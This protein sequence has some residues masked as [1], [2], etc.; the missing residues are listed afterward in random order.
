M[1]S[2][3][4]ILE[5]LSAIAH[6]ARVLAIVW[7]V[8]IAAVVLQ[9][10]R[11]WRPSRRLAMALLL[12]PLVTAAALGFA[13]GLPFNGV[14]LGLG[15]VALAI[16]AAG[17]PARHVVAAPPPAVV[18]GGALVGFGCWY[19]HFVDGPAL[20]YAAPVGLIPCPTLA[21]LL[22]ATLAAGGFHSSRWSTAVAALGLFY[23]VVGV[24]WLG[25]WVDAVLIGGAALTFVQAR[26][27][28]HRQA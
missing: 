5:Q 27:L 8:V 26:A 28:R 14:V 20:L 10:A 23:G 11:G 12:G 22:G 18:L 21:V 15:L 19:P 2:S 4:Q 25:V 24:A 17:S 6:D 7:H 3:N 16:V 1:P 13:H 9:A